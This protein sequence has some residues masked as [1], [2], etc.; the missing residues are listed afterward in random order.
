MALILCNECGKQISDKASECPG[1]GCS[2][3]PIIEVVPCNEAVVEVYEGKQIPTTKTDSFK[4]MRII[5]GGICGLVLG[6]SFSFQ[7]GGIFLAIFVGIFGAIVA[8]ID[9]GGLSLAILGAIVGIVVIAVC[10]FLNLL[11]HM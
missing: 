5:I 8:S 2:N 3:S 1:C 4:M 6:M 7:G 11:M 9:F 10:F